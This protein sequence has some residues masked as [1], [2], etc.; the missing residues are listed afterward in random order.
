MTIYTLYQ[1]WGGECGGHTRTWSKWM[2]IYT[3]YQ[4]WGGECGVEIWAWVWTIVFSVSRCGCTSWESE[5]RNKTT[6][7]TVSRDWETES[8][9]KQT[10]RSVTRGRGRLSTRTNLHSYRGEDEQWW[11][12]A[13]H[14]A[15][16]CQINNTRY[17]WNSSVLV[18]VVFSL[19]IN[20]A[21][22]QTAMNTV[23][24][25]SWDP[26]TKCSSLISFTQSIDALEEESGTCR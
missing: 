11:N 19:S 10:R 21:I 5:P 25:P 2:T 3:L 22:G 6:C 7:E 13:H 16:S 1:Q 18:Q 26:L 8:K 12:P 14:Q 17:S 4:Q 20:E 9:R 24:Y 23:T 15:V